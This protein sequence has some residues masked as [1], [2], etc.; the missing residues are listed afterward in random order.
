MSWES[1]SPTPTDYRVDWAKSDEEYT[2]WKVDDGHVY[3]AETATRAII[4]D[5][6]HNT[7]YKI[8][9]RARYYTGEHEDKSWGGQWAT[10]TITVV[11]EPAETPTPEPAETPTPEP[12]EE[13]PVE[14]EPVEK[15][16][17]KKEPGQRPPRSDPARD[18]PAP[19]DTTLAAGTI[20]T[21]TAAD[22]DAGQ[23]VLSWSAPAA[24]NADP[25]DYHVNWAKSAED[26]PADTA[27][28]GNAHPDST[29]HTLAGLEYDTDYNVR[30]RARYSNGENADSP[31]NGPWTETTAQVKL[32]LPAAPFIGAIAVTPDGDVNL[33]WFNL[34]EDDSITGY[35][36]LRGPDA[37]NLVV[38]EDDTESS[39]TTYTDTAPP[40]GQTHTYGVKAR[41]ASG[42][43]PLS[44]ITVT[45]PALEPEEEE[46]LTTASH[47]S[48]DETLVSNLGQPGGDSAFV[49]P[50]PGSTNEISVSFTT[51]D[52]SFGYHLTS[53]QLYIRTALVADTNTPNA[54]ASIRVDNGGTPSETVLSLLNTSTVITTDYQLTTFTKPDE[55]TI[56]LQPD[57]IY[58]LYISA[59]GTAAGVEKTGSNNQDAES[60]ADWRINDVRIERTDGGAWTTDVER[61]TLKMKILG[62][63]IEITESVSEPAD[64]DLADDDTTIGRLALNDGV[65]GRLSGPDFHD[66]DWFVFSAEAD[67]NYEFTAN[68][69]RRNLPYFILRIFNGEGVELRNSSIKGNVQ[70]SPMGYRHDILQWPCSTQRSSVPDTHGR[71]LLRVDRVVARELLRP[72]VHPC[73]VW[74]RLFR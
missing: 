19:E 21:L 17:G 62:H 37:D 22:D 7:E 50:S 33:V 61:D 35:Q 69:G 6:S 29:T 57:T 40:A 43:S 2:S 63:G 45:I 14:E 12:V 4:T 56:Q 44:T 8:R 31:W 24:P 41:N 1:A 67:T 68:P 72:F 10:K 5:L 51:G 28:A 11:G 32:P 9:I 26:Y 36:I 70:T 64:G 54:Q 71:Y 47:T 42:L 58:W 30:V 65:T 55:V 49:G 23:L 27:E 15:E 13:E 25:T 48:T 20:E 16:P 66:V 60:Q 3:P 59:T 53:V 38:I 34:D 74:R 46:E 52:N 18:D 39:S 73:H